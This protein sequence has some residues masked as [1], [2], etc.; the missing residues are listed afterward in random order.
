MVAY[1][2]LQVDQGKTDPMEPRQRMAGKVV[3]ITGAGRGFGYGIARAIGLEGGTVCISDI[4][5]DELRQSEADLSSQGITVTSE[6]QD[7]SDLSLFHDIVNRIIEQHGRLD[8]VIQNAAY[9]PLIPFDQTTEDSFWRQIHITL[10][11]MYNAIKASW[12]VFKSQGGGHIIGIGSGSSFRG[13]RNE[14]AYCAGK[15][16]EDGLIKSL[17]LEGAPYKISLNTIG[18]GKKIKPTGI[19]REQLQSIPTEVQASWY[20]PAILGRAFVWLINQPPGLFSGYRFDAGTI[21]DTIMREGL[22]FSFTPEKVTQHVDDF[23]ARKDWYEN[24]PDA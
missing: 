5:T 8:A 23:L 13:F 2:Y 12:D 16:A 22:N 18:P 10:G 14:S 4:N 6:R 7:I 15:H 3:L 19:T 20:D 17:A 9:L 24:Y 11:G 21:V 1:H